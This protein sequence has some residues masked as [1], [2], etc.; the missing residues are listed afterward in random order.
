MAAR[1]RAYKII[2]SFPTA[3]LPKITETK[4]KD[5]LLEWESEKI[6]CLVED[7]GFVVWSFAGASPVNTTFVDYHN[8]V[9]YLRMRFCC[10]TWMG[11]APNPASE[12]RWC[13]PVD[14]PILSVH[15]KDKTTVLSR[16]MWR[17]WAFY[18]ADK[19]T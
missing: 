11:L 15:P 2:K 6:S 12:T 16:G 1:K 13:T 3:P 18:E 7:D 9:D 14:V 5:I 10:P 17:D 19:T 8:I 4:H